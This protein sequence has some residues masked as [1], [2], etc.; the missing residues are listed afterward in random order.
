M[1][2]IHTMAVGAAALLL[3]I[4]SVKPL[5]AQNVIPIPLSMQTTG[6]K[7]LVWLNVS[8]IDAPAELQNEREHMERILRERAGMQEL[9]PQGTATITLSLDASL[10]DDEAYTLQLNAD[11]VRI[12]GRTAA[13]IGRAHV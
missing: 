11:G 7:P 9:N 12:S 2:L 8:S 5:A 10:S 13:E 4:G 6:E 1:N 3:S